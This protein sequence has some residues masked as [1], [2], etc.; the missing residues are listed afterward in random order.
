MTAAGLQKLFAAIAAAGGEARFVGGAVR[1]ALL[2][3]PVGDIDLAVNLS[4]EKVTASLNA[5]GIKVVPTGIAHGTVT[6]VIDHKGYEITALRRDVETDG[7]RAKVSF[8][9][10][11][12][13]DAVPSAQGGP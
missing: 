6:A 8:T 13:A 5:A 2:G 1:D 4:P 10:D 9:D 3:R 11:W 12:Q 7:R